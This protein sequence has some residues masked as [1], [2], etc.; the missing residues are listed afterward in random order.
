MF[1]FFDFKLVATKQKKNTTK[2]ELYLTIIITN[3]R[4]E[5]TFRFFIII[6]ETITHS[7][8]YIF[9]YI[10]IYSKQ[11]RHNWVH[12]IL[13]ILIF[14]VH[15]CVYILAFLY[16]YYI[17]ELK[18]KKD[19]II[20]YTIYIYI[21]LLFVSFV[22]YISDSL[23]LFFSLAFIFQC[24]RSITFIIYSCKLQSESSAATN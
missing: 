13:Q 7:A 2:K 4:K 22:F 16:K 9:I 1:F 3:N 10:S 15:L 8:W 5:R 19:S 14:L 18:W 23:S 20:I 17:F 12:N 6:T 11:I 21:L 24:L